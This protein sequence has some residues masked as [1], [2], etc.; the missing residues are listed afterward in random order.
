MTKKNLEQALTRIANENFVGLKD[1]Q[2][3][4]RQYSD[5]LD[6]HDVAV[7]EIKQALLAAY[8][9]GKNSK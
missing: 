3:L 6:F 9:L 2:D 7:W 1:R 4:E 8:E 5:E